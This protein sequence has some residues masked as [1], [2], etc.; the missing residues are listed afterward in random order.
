MFSFVD[1]SITKKASNVKIYLEEAPADEKIWWV[2]QPS[3]NMTSRLFEQITLQSVTAASCF[4]TARH[5][6][7][8]PPTVPSKSRQGF[9][10]SG[11]GNIEGTCKYCGLNKKFAANAWMAER[12]KLKR[13]IAAQKVAIS[14]EVVVAQTPR[15]LLSS[16]PPIEISTTKHTQVLDGLMHI[17]GGSGLALEM[18]ASAIDSGALFKHQFTLE[19]D[20]LALID[21]RLDEFFQIKSWEVTPTSFVFCGA[22]T[23]ITGFVSKSLLKSIQNSLTEGK[24]FGFEDED[25][26]TLPRLVGAKESDIISISKEM[27]I[28]YLRN[29]VIEMLSILPSITELAEVL[30]KK[31][32]PG[33]ESISQFEPESNSWVET[34]NIEQ[35]G[36]YR[37]RGEYRNRYIVRTSNDLKTNSVSFVSAELAKHFQAAELGRAL[38]AFNYSEKQLIVPLGASL[39]G[40]YG[41]AAVL[42]SGKLPHRDST[43]KL[44]IY[45]NIDSKTSRLFAAKLGGAI[46][47]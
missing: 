21:C 19:L 34:F 3:G 27:N 22:Y 24:V 16:M 10:K 13:E 30:P 8:I 7:V 1:G 47:G 37:I 9:E 33:F 43:G 45:N 46:H 26:F 5:N 39:P 28:P 31:A 41:R 35:V 4:G 20:Q 14:A 23:V 32:V 18:L 40:L 38:I 36:G 15:V 17:G 2:N 42:A 11:S 12:N 29:P 44:L 25:S 6:F